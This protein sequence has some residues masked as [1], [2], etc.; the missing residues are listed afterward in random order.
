MMQWQEQKLL[1]KQLQNQSI[2]QLFRMPAESKIGRHYTLNG[3]T[4]NE[5]LELLTNK[6]TN[7]CG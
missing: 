5:M 6:P 7:V 3:K 2:N 1:Q 4:P